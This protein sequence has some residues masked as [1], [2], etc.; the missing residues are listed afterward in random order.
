MRKTIETNR[1]WRVHWASVGERAGRDELFRQVE[2]TIGGKPEPPDQVG[3]LVEAIMQRLDLCNDDTLLDLC[4]GNGLITARLAPLCRAALG[5]D[6]SLELIEVALERHAMPNTVYLHRA[7]AE[8]HSADFLKGPPNKA[9][10]N[11]GLQYFTEAM[12]ERLLA[13][14]RALAKCKLSLYFTDVPD[15]AKLNAFYNTPGRQVEFERRRAAGTEAIGTWWDRDHL[16]SLFAAAGY[17]VSIV[18]PESRRRTAH[19]RFDVLAH[20]LR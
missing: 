18:E 1:D 5:I 7:A 3:L 8:I 10:M 4:C 14:L 20:L 15:A 6:Y 16:R 11:A 19:Y 12:V 9:C 2:R 17:A 13:T